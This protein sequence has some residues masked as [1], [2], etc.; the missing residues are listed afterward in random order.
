[1]RRAESVI[2]PVVGDAARDYDSAA[3]GPTMPDNP[4]PADLLSDAQRRHLA[5]VL[6][7]IELALRQVQLLAEG[8]EAAAAT[9]SGAAV[10]DLPSGFA[11][12]I[13][14]PVADAA[15]A[16]AETVATFD[17]EPSRVSYARS[18]EARVGTSLVILED[19]QARKLGGYGPIHPEL[20]ARL[21]PLLDR[22]KESLRR[23]E[24][25]V[26]SEK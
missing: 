17:L 14:G 10:H 15:E 18:V 5:T 2:V 12:V 24:T 4:P 26:R 9:H 23:I 20:P 3:R 11:A 8:S 19:T 25:A 21:D 16:I 7:R 1:M 22:L 6:S 13:E